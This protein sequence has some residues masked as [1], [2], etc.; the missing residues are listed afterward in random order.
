MKVFYE[1]KIYEFNE[2]MRGYDL[3]KKLGLNPEEHLIIVDGE[4]YTEDRVIKKDKE[5][6]IVKV[7][8]SG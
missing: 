7:T 6:K 8:S 4:L 2:S 1:F 3:L 5:V